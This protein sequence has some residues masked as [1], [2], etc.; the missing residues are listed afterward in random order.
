MHGRGGILI[1]CIYAV[2]KRDLER[3]LKNLYPDCLPEF[4]SG[5]D[6]AIRFRLV[7]KS[8]T[9]KSNLVCIWSQ[10]KDFL[11]RSFIE[12]TIKWA[13]RPDAGQPRVKTTNEI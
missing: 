8:G 11:K 1:K 13:K 4:I 3:K 12:H 2:A 10:N 7:G 6:S 5:N 9:Y